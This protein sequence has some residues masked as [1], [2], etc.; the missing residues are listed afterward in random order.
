VKLLEL[1]HVV[2]EGVLELGGPRV[3]SSSI[4]GRSV[5]TLSLFHSAP[6]E[7]GVEEDLPEHKE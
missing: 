1:C 3:S 7:Y 2:P 5:G 6:F 4:W